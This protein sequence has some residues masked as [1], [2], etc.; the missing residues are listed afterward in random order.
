[1]L[2]VVCSGWTVTLLIV[3]SN[4]TFSAEKLLQCRRLLFYASV[5]QSSFCTISCII[6]TD[7]FGSVDGSVNLCGQGRKGSYVRN[8]SHTIT[9]RKNVY[10]ANF[11]RNARIS[12]FT[13]ITPILKKIIG[14]EL[15]V[16]RIIYLAFKLVF[17]HLYSSLLDS[18]RKNID[19]VSSYI[20]YY[21]RYYYIFNP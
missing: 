3:S 11:K 12:S 5:L 16:L 18:R 10:V 8:I 20:T 15:G 2:L 9:D 19:F 1:M 17:T 21:R 4:S 13:C 6:S 14:I 7:S